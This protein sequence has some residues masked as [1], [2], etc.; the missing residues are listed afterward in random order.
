M[1]IPYAGDSGLKDYSSLGA[2]RIRLTTSRKLLQLK[3]TLKFMK[4]AMQSL[5]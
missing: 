5:L 4:N 1:Y 3:M 2:F